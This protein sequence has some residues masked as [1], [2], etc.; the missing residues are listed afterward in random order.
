MLT[1]RQRHYLLFCH[2]FTGCDTI[3]AIT[4]HGKSALFDKFCSEDIDKYMDIFL[5]LQATKDEVI[6]SGIAIFKYICDRILENLPF[7]HKQTF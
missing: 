5:N 3:S 2:A 4:G 1:E 7:G 6:R